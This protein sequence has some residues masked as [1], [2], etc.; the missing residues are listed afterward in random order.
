MP[1][2]LVALLGTDSVEVLGATSFSPKTASSGDAPVCF[3]ASLCISF[4]QLEKG[5][6][7]TAGAD[8][9]QSC[10]LGGQ[11]CLLGLLQSFALSFYLDLEVLERTNIERMHSLSLSTA[12]FCWYC[13]PNK[14]VHELNSR[15]RKIVLRVLKGL[16]TACTRTCQ[17]VLAT[18]YSMMLSSTQKIHVPGQLPVALVSLHAYHMTTEY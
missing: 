10:S 2:V 18:L 13:T 1:R 12:Y 15:S 7:L 4:Q 11:S 3:G 8:C 14:Y 17:H 5:G 6:L 16:E 9:R